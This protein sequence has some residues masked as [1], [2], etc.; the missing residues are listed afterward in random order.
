M[1]NPTTVIQS[2]GADVTYQYS[3]TANE[4]TLAQIM[5]EL[6]QIKIGAAH[7]ITLREKINA[8]FG[9]AIM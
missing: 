7:L 2:H 8:A 6:F 4:K 3:M 9:T 1:Q 5:G